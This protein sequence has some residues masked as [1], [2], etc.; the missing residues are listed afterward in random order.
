MRLLSILFALA[1]PLLASAAPAR[2]LGKRAA[3]D[4]LV[5]QFADVLEQ[6]ESTFYQQGL[7]KFKDTDFTAAG[8]SSSQIP[9]EQL[10]N[11]QADEA[12]HSKVLQAALKAAGA[13]PISGCKFNFDSVLTDVATMAATAR[14]VEIVGVNAY[15]GAATLLTDPVLLAAAGSILTVEARHQTVLNILSGSG[16]A[17][18]APFDVPFTPNEVLAIASQFISGCSLGVSSNTPLSIT[19]TGLV[20]PGTTLTFKADSI[21][22]TVSPD[23]LFCQMLIGGSPTAIPLP[24]S[25][26]VVPSGVNG[27]VALFVTSDGQPLLND[28]HDR[29]Q[30]QVVAGPTL[31]FI[32]AQPQMLPQ[33]VKTGNSSQPLNYTTTQTI[34][35]A[36]ASAVI[37]GAAASTPTS[38]ATSTDTA[39]TPSA[40]PSD[41]PP[42]S[43]G[44]S[45]SIVSSPGGKNT[46]T[47]PSPDGM[48]TVNGWS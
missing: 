44:S 13:Q 39:A 35:P 2:F 23:K 5:F 31:A 18:P 7:A 41:T 9:I 29:A 47:G 25:Q 20:T 12:T 42:G 1:V 15:L 28:V 11:I 21:N 4:I 36:Q 10:T 17:I 6:L 27:P 14:V 40:T 22:G 34:S 45:A 38:T 48:V 46:F 3:A 24:L 33:L 16:T 37:S 8:F 30:K 32:D 26:C 19:N 43:P